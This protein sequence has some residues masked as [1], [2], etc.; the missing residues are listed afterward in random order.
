VTKLGII[1]IAQQFIEE[2][3]IVPPFDSFLEAGKEEITH[4]SVVNI[5]LLSLLDSSSP[6]YQQFLM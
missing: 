3:G 6:L 5:L 2:L 4:G 1:P